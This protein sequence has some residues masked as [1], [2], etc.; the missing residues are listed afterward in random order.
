MKLQDFDYNLPAALIAQ[1]PAAA[2]D[3]SRLLAVDRASGRTEDRYFRDLPRY[4]RAG[5]VL[6]LN[7]SRVIRARLIGVKER[8]GGRIELFLLKRIAAQGSTDE[9]SPCVLAGDCWEVLA[10][11]AKRLRVGDRVTFGADAALT[12]AVLGRTEDGSLTVRFEYEGIFAEILERLGR[13]PLPPY[14]RRADEDQDAER[15]QTVYAAMPGS[16]AAPTAGLHFTERLL[17]EIRAQGV[18]TVFVTLHVGLGT[19]RPVQSEDVLR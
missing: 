17:D 3:G 7:D 10:R 16:A 4:L 1:Y 14:I 12:A 8:T 13:V 6:V 9:P 15:Y 5:D 19:F 18:E 2:R 11:P